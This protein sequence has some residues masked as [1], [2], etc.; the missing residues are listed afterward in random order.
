MRRPSE[1]QTVNLTEF[2]RSVRDGDERGWDAEFAWL[3][4]NHAAR[5]RGLFMSV[6]QHGIREPLL[7]GDDDRL[8]DGHHRFYVAHALGFTH[9]RVKNARNEDEQ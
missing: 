3:R 6:L 8:W 2:M 4:D 1:V 9:I 7:V 5:L